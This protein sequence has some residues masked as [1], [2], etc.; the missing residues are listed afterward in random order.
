[1]HAEVASFYYTSSCSVS[2][3]TAAQRCWRL[4]QLQPARR[5]RVART[6]AAVASS[7]AAPLPSWP[8]EEVPPTP[9]LVQLC[10]HQLQLV[11]QS[12]HL[13]SSALG[14]DE[15][16]STWLWRGGVFLRQ[17]SSLQDGALKLQQVATS[18]G[19]ASSTPH[20]C[21]TLGFD[22]DGAGM[23][24]QEAWLIEQPAIAL[25]DSGGLVL[26]LAHSDFLV[27]LLALERGTL[28]A[29]GAAAAPPSHA[30]PPACALL[31]A[32]ELALLRTAAHV[33]SA[34][35]AM[36]LRTVLERAAMGG[37]AQR[38]AAARELVRGTAGPLS[39]LRTLGTMLRGRLS[40]AGESVEGEMVE[41][42]LEQSQRLAEVVKAL[43]AALHPSAAGAA[44]AALQAAS[45]GPPRPTVPAPVSQR[46]GLLPALPSSSIGSDW[47]VRPAAGSSGNGENGCDGGGS[48]ADLPVPATSTSSSESQDALSAPMDALSAPMPAA[49][50]LCAASSSSSISASTDL[51]PVL[52]PLLAAASNLASVT[53]ASL[54]LV[55]SEAEA[56]EP[57]ASVSSSSGGG[58]SGI[59]HPI[60]PQHLR[61]HVAVPPALLRRMLSQLLDGMV[62]SA[63]RGDLIKVCVE[64]MRGGD[65][66]DAAEAACIVRLCIVRG[67]SGA[68]DP[69]L[70]V[71][72]GLRMPPR[73]VEFAFLDRMAAA[74]GGSL[75][76]LQDTTA[77]GWSRRDPADCSICAVLTLPLASA[78]ELN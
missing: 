15:L 56:S 25:P 50:A 28:P 5:W 17:P 42:I 1:M 45:S 12:L 24:D 38:Q 61:A 70:R 21:L 35:C 67:G 4:H 23:A 8:P 34:A 71:A 10:R 46:Q 72:H 39:T 7:A 43:Q 40:Q 65:G 26:P 53:G 58:G 49:L 62:A 66:V 41:T 20:H 73:P 3:R 75:E 55:P 60:A 6:P 77:S 69:S 29:G 57:E 52:M 31:G 18:D 37:V 47:F 13:S 27:G 36:E 11:V 59:Q 9:E 68:A 64:A 74:A 19:T 63:S 76:L 44:A 54:F 2:V 14:D 22:G 32:R 48:A 30:Q 16:P 78:G 51:F 33:L